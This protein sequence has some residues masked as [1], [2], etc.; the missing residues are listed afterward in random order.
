[1]SVHVYVNTCKNSSG[2]ETATHLN[3]IIINKINPVQTQSKPN[4][5]QHRTSSPPLPLPDQCADPICLLVRHPEP[6]GRGGAGVSV[7]TD[8]Y[9]YQS[10]AFATSTPT[11][12]VERKAGATKAA[13]RYRL[14][15][16]RLYRDDGTRDAPRRRGECCLL[17]LWDEAEEESWE[18]SEGKVCWRRRRG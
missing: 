1:M 5:H 15:S 4:E 2:I 6:S 16:V 10:E 18:R 17:F 7:A 11:L 9:I 8:G 12:T 13:H 14:N 3:N